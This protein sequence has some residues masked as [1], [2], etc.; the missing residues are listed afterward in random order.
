MGDSSMQMMGSNSRVID[1]ANS[2]FRSPENDLILSANCRFFLGNSSGLLVVAAAQGIPCVGVN[3][4]PAGA[5]KFWG[6][7][8]IAVPKIYRKVLDG[9]IISFIE[10]FD[11]SLADLRF[12]SEFEKVGVY[13]QE[14]S[15]DEILEACREMIQRL[16]RTLTSSHNQDLED[17]FLSLFKE[18]NYSYFSKTK[19]S[20]YFL[21]KYRDYY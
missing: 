5:A 8:D 21:K 13:L 12:T 17:R 20:S 14:N 10:V 3:L 16:D 7:N 1:Y 9:T 15:P 11:S 4:A 6:P 18:N 19:F 2:E